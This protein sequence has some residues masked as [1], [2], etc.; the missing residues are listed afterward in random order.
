[1]TSFTFRRE[2]RGFRR[3]SSRAYR[4]P[5]V[6]ASR[7]TTAPI[8]A[9]EPLSPRVMSGF[10]VAIAE[11]AHMRKLSGSSAGLNLVEDPEEYPYSSQSF[12]RTPS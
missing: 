5:R 8:G 1:M 2:R 6:S 12:L 7:S 4:L 3:M 10:D 9:A 11:S